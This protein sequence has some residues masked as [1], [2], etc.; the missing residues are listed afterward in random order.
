[1]EH[2]NVAVNDIIKNYQQ[3]INKVYPMTNVNELKKIWESLGKDSVKGGEKKKK[4]AYQ[5]FFTNK[6]REITEKNPK[7]KF[8]DISKLIS[9]E[10]NKLSAAE[11]KNYEEVKVSSTTIS[12]VDI[13]LNENTSFLHLFDQQQEDTDEFRI[14]YEHDDMGDMDDDEDDPIDE[15]E[16]D[17][18]DITM[19]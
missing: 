14:D 7:L 11:K 12:P 18:D 5:M 16:I 2:I 1:M 10:W 13:S 6:R 9:A 17:F 19:E 15:E 8:G 3:E 4:T